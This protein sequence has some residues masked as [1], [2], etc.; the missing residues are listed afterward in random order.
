MDQT[1]F[2]PTSEAFFILLR[3]WQGFV[4]IPVALIHSRIIGANHLP[5]LS[6]TLLAMRFSFWEQE[7]HWGAHLGKNTSVLVSI[8]CFFCRTESNAASASFLTQ[9]IAHVKHAQIKLQFFF[10]N[11]SFSIIEWNSNSNLYQHT[12]FFFSTWVWDDG[13]FKSIFWS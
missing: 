1:H 11:S 9:G 10:L 13:S 8:W 5:H 4:S 2:L 6:L 3:E 12:Y 7:V